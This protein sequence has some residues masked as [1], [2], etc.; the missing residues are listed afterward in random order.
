M[1]VFCSQNDYNS[2]TDVVLCIISGSFGLVYDG[3]IVLGIEI[4]YGSYF[5]FFLSGTVSSTSSH[6]QSFLMSSLETY[7]DI[8]VWF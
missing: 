8:Y 2:F 4:F 7:S 1:P 6:R 5:A 3:G